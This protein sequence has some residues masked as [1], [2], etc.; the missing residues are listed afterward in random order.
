MNWEFVSYSLGNN[1]GYQKPEGQVSIVDILRIDVEDPADIV[2]H[3][4]LAL[5]THSLQQALERV[6]QSKPNCI[7]SVFFP[8][9]YLSDIQIV[10]VCYFGIRLGMSTPPPDQSR[11]LKI[12]KYLAL[13]SR[14]DGIIEV[15]CYKTESFNLEENDMFSA[16][17]LANPFIFNLCELWETNPGVCTVL[18]YAYLLRPLNQPSQDIKEQLSKMVSL[19][20]PNF[21]NI[22]SSLQR[23]HILNKLNCLVNAAHKQ[24]RGDAHEIVGR[25]IM[26]DIGGDGSPNNVPLNGKNIF[27]ADESEREA[28]WVNAGIKAIE[29]IFGS[30]LDLQLQRAHYEISVNSSSSK[31]MVNGLL[32]DGGIKHRSIMFFF[33]NLPSL[34]LISDA[35]A[36]ALDIDQNVKDFK[37]EIEMREGSPPQEPV[38]IIAAPTYSNEVAT[39]FTYRQPRHMIGPIHLAGLNKFFAERY[40]KPGNELHRADDFGE[41]MEYLH[42]SAGGILFMPKVRRLFKCIDQARRKGDMDHG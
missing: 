14:T 9:A 41:F 8:A 38:V 23:Q 7:T 39:Y 2:I 42:A 6:R 25:L 4:Q 40:S 37:E 27:E 26:R 31:L 21:D 29:D 3:P 10:L 24:Y 16:E 5:D 12:A 19:P 30:V 35:T 36:I 32:I 28:L 11:H 13:G 15:L 17:E 18:Y 22:I 1:S 20:G 33:F 34:E